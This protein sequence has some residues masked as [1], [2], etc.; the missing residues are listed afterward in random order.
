[1]DDAYDPA[2]FYILA[3]VWHVVHRDTFE[4]LVGDA[5]DGRSY[6]PVFSDSD[7]AERFIGRVHDPDRIPLE[8]QSPVKWLEFLE[9]LR[10]EG[11]EYIA[12]DPDPGKRLRIAT[13]ENVIESVRNSIEREG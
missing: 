1:M 5:S 7:L 11:H 8:F 3:S 4:V 6:V 13:I 2:S 9:A 10:K 12:I